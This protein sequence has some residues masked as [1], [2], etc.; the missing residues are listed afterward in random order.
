MV[1]LYLFL[2]VIVNRLTILY[3]SNS[4]LIQYLEITACLCTNN[5]TCNFD[6]TTT[7]STHYQL[8]SCNCP[9]QYDGRFYTYESSVL[10]TNY[11]SS[12]LGVLC[13][14][15]YNGCTSGSACRVNWNNGTTCV[16]LN[17]TQQIAL[18][19]AYTCNGACENGYYTTDNL[20]C[21]GMCWEKLEKIMYNKSHFRHQWM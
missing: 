12:W 21:Q 18:N 5:G 2:F 15:S 10:F 11:F 19:R 4:T 16:P 17:A 7:I 3:G 20:T 1:Q 6:E 9:D 8:A 14:L 13:E